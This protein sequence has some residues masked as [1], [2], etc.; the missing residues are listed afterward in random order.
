MAGGPHGAVL[1]QVAR[2]FHGGTV[3]G[4]GEGQL[5]ERFVTRGDEVAFE[6]LV[7]RHGPMV[8]GVCRRVL[9]DPHDVEDAFQATFLILARKAGAIERRDLLSPWLYGVACRVANR[10]RVQ[11]ARRRAH[12][13]PGEGIEAPDRSSEDHDADELREVLDEEVGHL[14]ERYRLPILLCYFEGL[15]HDEAA[16]RLRWPLGTVRSRMARGRDVLRARLT[17]RGFAPTAAPLGVALSRHTTLPAL[18]T[19]LL[20]ATAK[21]ATHFAA[22]AGSVS[23]SASVAALTEGVLRAMFWTSLKSAAAVLVTVGVVATGAGVLAYSG[24]GDRKQSA[25][26][27]S[28]QGPQQQEP[29]GG[30]Q[31]PQPAP[32]AQEQKSAKAD[33][34]NRFRVDQES[35]IELA[36]RLRQARHELNK[37]QELYANKIAG[38]HPY[39]LAKD[40]YD[41]LIARIGAQEEAIKDELELLDVPR[42]AKLA[43]LDRARARIEQARSQVA[44]YEK[45]NKRIPGAVAREEVEIAEGEVQIREAE[46]VVKEAELSEI[47]VRITQLKRRL[48]QFERLRKPPPEPAALPAAPN[49]TPPP[50]A[51][52]APSP[53][54]RPEGSAS[55]PS[56]PVKPRK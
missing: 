15:T 7:A 55:A 26:Q 33:N 11:A 24:P 13:Q 22:R 38:E 8:L 37:M 47:A 17:R 5:L 50:P 10:A 30:A 51:P 53:V 4:V 43:E 16:E 9:R 41:L 12:E 42:Q 34:P 2:L 28:P 49:R 32:D 21:A 25:Q 20:H 40:A 48:A 36:V 39:I 54:R 56:A 23:V 19:T 31:L 44:K 18:P 14:P 1:K 46:R 35:P 3:A 6:A 27:Q 45:L 29:S 52:A